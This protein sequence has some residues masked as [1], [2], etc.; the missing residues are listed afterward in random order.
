MRPGHKSGLQAERTVPGVA[1]GQ[2]S[3]PSL[4]DTYLIRGCVHV[5]SSVI[6]S[7]HPEHVSVTG[8]LSDLACW[9]QSS[10]GW[11]QSVLRVAPVSLWGRVLWARLLTPSWAGIFSQLQGCGSPLASVITGCIEAVPRWVWPQ[12]FLGQDLPESQQLLCPGLIC[13]H[14]SLWSSILL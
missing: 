8:C 2:R 11:Q 7:S 13:C 5:C 14:R 10:P 6:L 1:W 12:V 4:T 9:T 3:E